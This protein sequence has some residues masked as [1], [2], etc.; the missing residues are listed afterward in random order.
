MLVKRIKVSEHGELVSIVVM[1]DKETKFTVFR[2]IYDSV[3][4]P[5]PSDFLSEDAYLELLN[6]DECYRAVKKALSLLSFSDNSKSALRRKLSMGGFSKEASAYAVD[7]AVSL[8]YINELDALSRLVVREASALSG[9]RKICAKLTA[10]GY[11]A[12]DVKRII[13]DLTESG[14][15]DFAFNLSRLKEKHLPDE[16]TD[17]DVKRLRFKFGY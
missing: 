9:P 8:G 17:E 13:N 11:N 16:F 10:K 2:D 4:A 1:A 12:S 7:Y 3:G 14:E 6:G 5:T 15:I